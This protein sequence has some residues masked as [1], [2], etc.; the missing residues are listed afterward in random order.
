VFD[1][2]PGELCVGVSVLAAAA[3]RSEGCRATWVSRLRDVLF[4]TDL[5]PERSN[6]TSTNRAG[7]PM[8]FAKLQ[9]SLAP[10][11]LISIAR[12][13]GEEHAR[14][15]GRTDLP[16]FTLTQWLAMVKARPYARWYVK[17]DDDTMVFP[18]N[19]M[20]LL[21]QFDPMTE[22]VF[23]GFEVASS[24]RATGTRGGNYHFAQGG[25]GIIV[26]HR[27]MHTLIP[28][29]D[30]CQ[31]KFE[32]VNVFDEYAGSRCIINALGDFGATFGG[33]E[34]DP[35]SE[36]TTSPNA[37]KAM[38]DGLRNALNQQPFEWLSAPINHP[39]MA[40]AP[41][42]LSVAARYLEESR[43]L[44]GITRDDPNFREADARA[45]YH[46]W[47]EL[48][49][50]S[51]PVC[52]SEMRDIWQAATFA[53][54]AGQPITY[55][56][57][58]QG[59]GPRVSPTAEHRVDLYWPEEMGK[60]EVNHCMRLQDSFRLKEPKDII[61]TAGGMGGG[62]GAYLLSSSNSA[63]VSALRRLPCSE[64]YAAKGYPEVGASHG[65]YDLASN[66]GQATGHFGHDGAPR[67]VR[68]GCYDGS[69]A[70]LLDWTVPYFGVRSPRHCTRMCGLAG[71]PFAGVSSRNQCACGSHLPDGHRTNESSCNLACEL[72]APLWPAEETCGGAKAT[73]VY[74]T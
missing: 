8:L 71:F 33:K 44:G 2:L 69:A 28:Y 3:S 25:A 52:G 43:A 23:R 65:K 68:A 14:V 47:D 56:V 30:E 35:V 57:L 72:K 61:A 55:D 26:S 1:D 40:N 18:P 16:G 9:R 31:K 24:L 60:A 48:V 73:A 12:S 15:D 10:Y 66:V 39:G 58:R 50:T 49:I 62:S 74:M 36:P 51:H 7:D 22:F 27:L 19:L 6:T 32:E 13:A 59:L 41:A 54:A 67:P 4:F 11:P 20:A 34:Y 70:D 42:W 38:R 45:A 37:S 5:V 21:R 64:Q 53:M 46:G 17:V 63:L 29:F